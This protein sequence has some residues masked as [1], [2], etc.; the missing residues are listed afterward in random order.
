MKR[1]DFGPTMNALD[2]VSE[3]KGV[4][5]A[6][7][8]LKNRKKLEAQLE[9]DKPIFET[10]LTPSEGFKEYEDKR[11]ELCEAHSEKDDE[12]KALTEGD[13]YKIIDLK[14]FNDELG[15]LSQE[16]EVS[17]ADR[18]NQIEEYNELMEEDM[19]IDFQ[20]LGFDDLPEDLTE[21]QLRSLEFMLDLD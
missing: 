15:A 8:V 10:I 7:A 9:E 17:I 6:F 21:S 11:I 4:K 5:F 14:Q 3:L 18:K 1:K 2:S 12:G 16:Y 20:T 19:S 13:K